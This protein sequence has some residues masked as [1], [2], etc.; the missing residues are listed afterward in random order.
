MAFRGALCDDPTLV[1]ALMRTHI[2]TAVYGG[3]VYYAESSSG[4][5]LGVAVWF[6]PGQRFLDTE[7][8]R[9]AG[10]Y[11]LMERL[12]QKSRDWWKYFNST[13]NDAA[14]RVF[15]DGAKVAAYHLQMFGVIPERQRQGIGSGLI[16]FVEEKAKAIN[17]DL[18]LETVGP[19][20]VVTRVID[21][22]GGMGFTLKGTVDVKTFSGVDCKLVFMWK[23]TTKDA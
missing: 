3:E 11:Q 15:G 9:Q 12:D 17:V 23:N 10:W 19:E 1:E 21:L 22:Y 8:Q 13:Y 16:N 2:T 18:C 20:D 6:G 5:V 14:E 4:D 7:G